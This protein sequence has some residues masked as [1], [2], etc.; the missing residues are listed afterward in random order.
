MLAHLALD[1]HRGALC[2]CRDWPAFLSHCRLRATSHP[3]RYDLTSP[4]M[5]HSYYSPA[6]LAAPAACGRPARP[7]LAPLPE[8]L[9]ACCDGP[10]G[11][12]RPGPFHGHGHWCARE[13]GCPAAGGMVCAE[14]FEADRAFARCA[15]Y[16]RWR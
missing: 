3:N 5:I 10:A 11:E 8:L 7:D 16:H 15:T 2:D 14:T 13:V 6:A 9:P 4:A 12:G 1:A